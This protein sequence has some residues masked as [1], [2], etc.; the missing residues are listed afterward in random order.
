MYY[1]IFKNIKKK[2]ILLNYI[3]K[4]DK[5]IENTYET[6]NKH[7]SKILHNFSSNSDTI[8][9]KMNVFLSLSESQ[10][11]LSLAS[12]L[13]PPMAPRPRSGFSLLAVS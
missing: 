4:D 9:Q 12:L 10:L 6:F 7:I 8:E 1:N 5:T 2:Q 3:H 11:I 13:I